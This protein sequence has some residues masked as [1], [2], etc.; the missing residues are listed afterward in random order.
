MMNRRGFI[1]AMSALL[2]ATALEPHALLWTQ[3]PT[4]VD[5]VAP[6][7]LLTLERITRAI[8]LE[9]ARLRSATAAYEPDA[10]LIGHVGT[11]GQL[12]AHQFSIE[13][14]GLPNLVDRYG[15]DVE[16]YVCPAAK[17]LHQRLARVGRIS[18]FGKLPSPSL[19]VVEG[20]DMESTHYVDQDSGVAMR[21]IHA[22]YYDIVTM[23]VV[24]TLRFD[25]LVAA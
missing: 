12:F 23:N 16:R 11:R 7:A 14:D 1:G 22:Q 25:V 4:A 6:D 9:L 15:L 2:G 5:I 17:H 20:Q 13:M 19:R 10:S 21:G 8:A 24:N 18:G 3:Q